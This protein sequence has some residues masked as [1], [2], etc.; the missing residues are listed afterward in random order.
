MGT[1]RKGEWVRV[2]RREHCQ[3]CDGA[4]YCTRTADGTLARCQR[5]ESDRPS[6]KGGWLHKLTE[7]LPYVAPAPKKKPKSYAEVTQLAREM[8][9][10]G[11]ELRPALAEKLGVTL[12]SLEALQVGRGHDYQ[13]REYAAF[14][15]RDEYGRV[16][17]IVRRYADG[18]KKTLAGTSNS[19]VFAPNEWWA[20]MGPI[21]LVEGASDTAA[22]LSQ[23]LAVIGRPS[24]TG[25][26]E[27]IDAMLAR[28]A[29]WRKVV[30]IGEN[31]FKPERFEEP[32][33]CRTKCPGCAWCWPGKYG[34]MELTNKLR[35][36]KAVWIMPPSGIKDTREWTRQVTF[37]SELAAACEAEG[38]KAYV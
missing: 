28:R 16:I 13:G 33:K 18:A 35:S 27:R 11:A 9:D 8:Y 38:V 25:G 17:G 1:N 19:G 12:A 2:T 22:L 21:Y 6:K 34:A 3:V 23:E 20:P 24:N 4:D 37:R 36:R 7:P 30:V 15:S 10:R 31:D 26:Y 14:P 32:G 5:V 29:D